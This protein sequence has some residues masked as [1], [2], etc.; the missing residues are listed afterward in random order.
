MKPI[1]L[2]INDRDITFEVTKKNIKNFYLRIH[3][4]N[5]IKVSA[6]LL[7]LK[8]SI[9]RNI[10]EKRNW[11]ESQIDKVETRK[12]ISNENYSDNFLKQKSKFLF[13]DRISHCFEIFNTYYPKKK[14][15]TLR[16]RKMK[17]RWGSMSSKGEMTLNLNL[18]NLETKLIDY[19]I[20]HELAHMIEMNHSKKY[21]IVLSKI[22]PNWKEEKQKL[23]NFT[24]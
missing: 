9:I 12:E 19:V 21:Y 4:K 22:M 1:T 15:P 14:R 24:C 20:M 11:I 13:E 7:M 18:V 6:P 2:N 5:L 17:S 23:N 16:I 10:N 8:S 3:S